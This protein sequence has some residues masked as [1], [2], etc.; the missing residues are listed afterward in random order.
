[1]SYQLD[2][3]NLD[4]YLYLFIISTDINQ[5]IWQHVYTTQVVL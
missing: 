1:M 2:K 4:I 5:S 3:T